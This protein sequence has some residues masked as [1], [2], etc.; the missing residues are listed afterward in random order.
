MVTIQEATPAEKAFAFLALLV[1]SLPDEHYTADA[2]RW[3]T[4]V[5]NLRN[6][7]GAKYPHL[8]R[9]LHFRHVPRGDSYSPEVS[10]FLSFL[11]FTD[12]TTVHNPGFTRM[13]LQPTARQ[14]LQKRYQVHFSPEELSAVEQM[15]REVAQQK[16]LEPW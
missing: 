11:Q 6:K 2:S 16:V 10:N 15:S 7:Y 3:A 8:F 1:V 13:E 12:A 5:S 4:A 14:I 9:H